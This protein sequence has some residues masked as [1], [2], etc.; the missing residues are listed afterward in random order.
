MIARPDDLLAHGLSAADLADQ[1]GQRSVSS[2]SAGSRASRSP[3]RSWS[4]TRP[5]TV[6]QIEELVIS[7]ARDQPL[8]VRDVA[9]VKVLHQDRVLSIG[10]DQKDA[11]VIT[12]FRA[13]AATRSTSR[14]T[15]TSCWT[16]TA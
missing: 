7:R 11:V 9:D 12:V 2:R 13:W 4:T 5:H 8:R 14:T 3:F 10:F 15:C 16:A 1:I 6:Q